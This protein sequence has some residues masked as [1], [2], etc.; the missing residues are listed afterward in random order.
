MPTDRAR[1]GESPAGERAPAA[2]DL[3]D[4]RGVTPEEQELLTGAPA[5]D[6]EPEFPPADRR[7]A[8]SDRFIGVVSGTPNDDA[9]FWSFGGPA[10]TAQRK[11]FVEY[12]E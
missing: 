10:R 6:C 5:R 9:S 2:H 8:S 4:R 12:G 3:D 11:R 1:S 7:G